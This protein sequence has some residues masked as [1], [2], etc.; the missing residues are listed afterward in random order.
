MDQLDENPPFHIRFGPDFCGTATRHV[1]FSIQVD[2]KEYELKEKIRAPTDRRT[3]AYTLKIFPDGAFHIGVDAYSYP[4]KKFT[5]ETHMP[6]L[7]K[8]HP[9]WQVPVLGSVVIDVWQVKSGMMFD[10]MLITDTEDELLEWVDAKWNAK[11]VDEEWKLLS[12]VRAHRIL[13]CSLSL[14]Q[15]HRW[16]C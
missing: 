14:S 3:H 6:D 15:P 4:Y 8:D 10:N 16:T 9:N 7:H 11:H 5:L 1:L 2:G 13:P 12:S